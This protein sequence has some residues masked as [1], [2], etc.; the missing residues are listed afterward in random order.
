MKKI[1]LFSF[2]MVIH[3]F[4][5]TNCTS[6]KIELNSEKYKFSVNANK[7]SQGIDFSNNLIFSKFNDR[8]EK[9]LNWEALDRYYKEVMISHKNHQDLGFF[10]QRAMNILFVEGTG[11][12]KLLFQY[13]NTKT[14]K[15][16]VE[17]YAN[18]LMTLEYQDALLTRNIAKHLENIWTKEKLNSY[19]GEIAKHNKEMLDK[20]K[21]YFTNF[22]F[23]KN[24]MEKFPQSVKDKITSMH[25][26]Q[27]QA[28]NY[29]QQFEVK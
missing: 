5:M 11:N 2:L 1:R 15:E 7:N 29:I 10:K 3:I 16:V 23:E 4:I 8:V 25:D 22:D 24:G 6:S 21:N 13:A 9:D 26:K 14:H 12:S 18:E 20:D 27:I 17:Y 28:I 19:L